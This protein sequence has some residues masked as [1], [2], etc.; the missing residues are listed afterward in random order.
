[1]GKPGPL[2]ESLN[3]DAGMHTGCVLRK[4]SSTLNGG[5]FVVMGIMYVLV[6]HPE[7]VVGEGSS[8]RG[9]VEKTGRTPGFLFQE[10][11]L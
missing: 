9:A 5:I 10:V 8:R 2:C 1:M 11:F 3:V 4:Y 7:A 6:F